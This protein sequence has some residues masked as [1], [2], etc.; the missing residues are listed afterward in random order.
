MTRKRM[1]ASVAARSH[2]SP[3]QSHGHMHVPVSYSQRPPFAHGAPKRATHRSL[4]HSPVPASHTSGEASV[5]AAGPSTGTGPVCGAEHRGSVPSH[6]NGIARPSAPT[7]RGSSR[8]PPIVR[9]PPSATVATVMFL[10]VLSRIEP[11]PRWCA[12]VF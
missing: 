7:S 6:G 12:N 1:S 9:L 4:R 10:A 8:D 2:V 5:T 11:P 3:A